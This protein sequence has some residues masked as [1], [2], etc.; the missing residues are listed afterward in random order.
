MTKKELLKRIIKLE[1]CYNIL[2]N[3]YNVNRKNIQLI[4]NTLKLKE[5]G[6]FVLR[7]FNKECCI[8]RFLSENK[9]SI[10]EKWIPLSKYQDYSLNGNYIEIYSTLPYMEGRSLSLVFEVD[11]HKK[12]IVGVN[13]DEYFKKYGENIKQKEKQHTFQE[14][15]YI[16][17]F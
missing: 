3:K 17:I 1:N 9:D 10:V 11:S 8:V 2:E 7:D 12:D 14:L 13:M 4:L 5:N 15:P 16:S 6:F